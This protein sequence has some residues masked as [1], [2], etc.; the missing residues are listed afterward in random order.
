MTDAS[1]RILVV[2][3]NATTARTLRLFLEAE[4][5]DVVTAANGRDGL[6]SFDA[7]SIQL[8]ILDLMLPDVDGLSVCR[9]IRRQSATPVVMLTARTADDDVVEGLEAGA[10]DYVCKPFASKVLLARV[11]RCLDR[12]RRTASSDDV[13]QHNRIRID[14]ARRATYLDGEPIRL[15]RMEFD[16]L[17]RLIR[18]PGRVFT[19]AQLIDATRPDGADSFDR[20]IDTH[21]WNLRKKLGEPPGRP[22]IILSEPGVGYR[23]SDGDEA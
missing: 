5:Y 10:D 19:R 7:A 21:V 23:M 20:A 4:G 1:G 9:A 14:T 6:A 2:E 13:L 11:R 3:D 8:V 18:Q 16:I 15:T 22:R 17:Q 12:S